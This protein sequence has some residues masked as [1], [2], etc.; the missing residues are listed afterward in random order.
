MTCAVTFL[1]TLKDERR[2]SITSLLHICENAGGVGYSV[3]L[4]FRYR[5]NAGN[6]LLAGV[7]RGGGYDCFWSTGY[8]GRKYLYFK[9]KL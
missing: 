8:K 5:I 7:C 1:Y 6:G 2:S 4:S 3:A 9:Y